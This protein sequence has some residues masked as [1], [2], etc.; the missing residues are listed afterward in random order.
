MKINIFTNNFTTTYAR[1]INDIFI[2]MFSGMRKPILSFVFR[3]KYCKVYIYANMNKKQP[4][5]AVKLRLAL[6]WLI[7]VFSLLIMLGWFP[8]VISGRM[9]S[10]HPCG[11]FVKHE[12]QNGCH[13][14]TEVIFS[15]IFFIRNYNKTNP[16]IIRHDYIA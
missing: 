13:E 1:D 11:C 10:S 4:D 9:W 6:F 8:M 14:I 7:V 15:I 5:I 2:L 3:E 12:I 16:T